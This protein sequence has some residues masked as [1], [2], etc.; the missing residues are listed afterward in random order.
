MNTYMTPFRKSAYI[1]G[2]LIDN[3]VNEVSWYS[4]NVTTI[5]Y[6]KYDIKK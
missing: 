4:E 3:H 6:N 1:T 2:T 5:N